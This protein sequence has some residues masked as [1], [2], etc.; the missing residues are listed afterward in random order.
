[1]TTYTRLEKIG[2]G[3]L[4]NVFKVEDAKKNVYAMKEIPRSKLN[5]ERADEYLRTEISIMRYQY[6]KLISVQCFIF[7]IKQEICSCECCQVVRLFSV[8]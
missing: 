5:Y 3:C 4:A 1:M 6:L 7:V 8:S 2:S